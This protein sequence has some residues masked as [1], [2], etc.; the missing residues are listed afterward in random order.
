MRKRRQ[1]NLS[2]SLISSL[3]LDHTSLISCAKFVLFC[4]VVYVFVLKFSLVVSCEFSTMSVASGG[5]DPHRDSAPGPSWGT[6][7]PQ[8]PCSAYPFGNSCIRTARHRSNTG[9]SP[10]PSDVL[11]SRQMLPAIKSIAERCLFTKQY[12]ACGEIGHFCVL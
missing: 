1:S 2:K 10:S 8:T 6:S 5:E 9:R 3:W 11:L 12:V 4:S 7:I